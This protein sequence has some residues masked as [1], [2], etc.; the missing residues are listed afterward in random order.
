M[1]IYKEMEIAIDDVGIY[2][3]IGTG[4]VIGQITRQA[5]DENLERE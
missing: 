5:I 4:L 2:T 1:L 3:K